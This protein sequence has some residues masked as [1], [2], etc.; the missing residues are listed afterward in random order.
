MLTGVHRVAIVWAGQHL[1]THLDDPPPE[2]VPLAIPCRINLQGEG[3]DG[4]DQHMEVVRS[5]NFRGELF[6]WCF[7]IFGVAAA[8]L[9]L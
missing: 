6:L 9:L 1:C 7:V 5:S 2:G 3:V 8:L 4:Y